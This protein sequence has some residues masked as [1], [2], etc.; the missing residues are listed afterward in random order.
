MAKGISRYTHNLRKASALVLL[1]GASVLALTGTAHAQDDTATAATDSSAPIIVTGTRIQ[2]VAPVGTDIVAITNEDL[3]ATGLSSTADILNSVPSILQI[4][5]GNAYAGGQAQQSS[6]LTS[7]TFN[8]SPNIRGLGVGATLSLVN[9]HRVPY[10]GGNMNAFDGDNFPT[11]MIGRIEVLEDGG[12]ALYGADAIA[13]T[14]NYILRKPEDTLEV[15]AGYGSNEGDQQSYYIT[16]IGGVAWGEGTSGEGGLIVSYSHSYQEAFAAGKRPDLYNDDFSPYGGLPSPVYSSPGNVFYKGKY[17]AIPAGQNGSAI[18]LSDLNPNAVNRQNSWTNIEVIPEVESDRM[19]MNFEQNF[20]DSVRLFADAFYTRRELFINGPGGATSNRALSFGMLPKIPNS[21]PFSPCNPSHYPGGIVTG[22][23]ELLEACGQGFLEVA[24]ST[25]NDIGTP[26]RTATTESFTYGGGVDIGLPGDWNLTVTAYTGAYSAP[27]VSTQ[28]G[29]SP[30]PPIG[31]F[32]YFC[33]ASEFSCTDNASRTSILAGALSLVDF[34]EYS[35]QDY[36]ANLTGSLFSLPAGSVKV[37]VGAQYYKGSFKVQN[38]FGAN[39]LNKREVKSV[40]GELYVPL[41]GPESN[42]PAINELELTAAVRYDD[43]SDAGTT[44]NPKFGINWHV[45]DDFKLF[46]SYSTSFRA[47]GLA[48]NDPYSQ[49]GVIPGS[50]SGK[51]ISASICAACQA[52]TYDIASIYQTI[53]GANRDLVPETSKTYSFGADWRPDSIPGLRASIKYW[54]ISYEGQ[55][56]AP[57]YS[58]GAVAAI[59]RGIYNSQIIYNPA[60]FPAL[61]ASNPEAFFTQSPTI[62]TANPNCAAA[63]GKPATTQD[64]FD[65]MILCFNTGGERGGLFGPPSAANKVLAVINGRRINSGTTEGDGIDFTLDYRMDT[66]AGAF[67]LG[68]MGSYIRHWKVSPIAGA[69]LT[70]EVN[71]FGYPL[72]LR[73]RAQLGWE[74]D[75]GIGRLMANFFVNYANGYKMNP[76]SLPV[77]VPASYAD[78]DASTTV[79]MMLGL[80][81]GDTFSGWLGRDISLSLGVQNLFNTDP[82]LVINQ[83][84]LAGPGLRF[85]PTYGNPLGR[86]FQIQI[87]KKF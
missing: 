25:V 18:K 82:P 64:I 28:T 80:D 1:G 33:D 69:P 48:D 34:N 43:Y 52:S 20:G 78:I 11:Q 14:V 87:G 61:A 55:V 29:G 5:A 19:S 56:N 6:T 74:K 46:G 36:Q 67:N 51:Q 63:L 17:Y 77:G 42:V 76:A 21:N 53:G 71:T 44:T 27:S 24:Y 86:S 2:G 41:V 47:P 22:P 40:F 59:N 57:A 62:N 81:T 4:G 39:Q 70:D 3:T 8:K 45:T 83:S 38:N 26:T 23:A 73:A 9:G 32:N 50:N 49:S 58:V 85:D 15:Y 10:E 75:T 65:A 30:L 12:S 7:F 37:A 84:G 13:G 54:W 66:S 79:D 60:L 31:T 35:M 72:R 16:G 68:V